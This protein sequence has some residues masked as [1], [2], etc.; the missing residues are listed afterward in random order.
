[1]PVPEEV[2]LR[3]TRPARYLDAEPNAV[4]KSHDE[5]LVRFVLAYPDV[6]EV[7]MSNLGLGLL[8]HALNA[9]DDAL[10]E[11][12]FCP[13]P[14]MEAELRR[15][16]IPLFALE[17]GRPVREFDLLG[18]SLQ[19]ELTYSNILN[20]LDLARVPLLAA[21]RGPGDP[22][23]VGGGPCAYNP[24]PLAPFFDLFFL[25]E[26]EEAVGEL[27]EVVA[28]GRRRGRWAVDGERGAGGGRLEL[29]AELARVPGVY[30]P[31]FYE[32]VYRDDGRVAEIRVLRDGVPERVVKRVVADLDR[33]PVPEAPVVPLV[34]AVHDRAAVEVMRGCARGC[35]FCQAGMIYRPVRERSPRRV[36]DAVRAILA[37]TG[38][39]EVSLASLST[40]DWGPVAAVLSH[41]VEEH[42]PKGIAVSLPSLRT[43]TFAVEL[44]SKIQEVRKTGLTFAPEAATARLRAVINKGVT[45]AD[46]VNAARAAFEAGWD[47]LKLYYMLGLPT[48][49]DEDLEAIA[50]EAAEVQRIYQERSGP[51]AARRPLLLTVSLATFIP[52]AHTPFQWAPQVTVE[53]AERRVAVVREAL[54][55]SRPGSA[56]RSKRRAGVKLDWHSPAMSRLEAVLARG[57]RR[58]HRAVLK[59]WRKGA[60]FDGWTEHFRPELWDSAFREEG[61]DPSFYANRA[62]PED[63]V[64]PWE[65]L[66]SGVEREFL[67]GEWHR[68]LAGVPTPD[69]RWTACA[70]CGV[71]ETT[72][73][74]NR[75]TGRGAGA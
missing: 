36:E 35:R 6:Y 3:V 54:G 66:S 7:G 53:E 46:L 1:M 44:A 67:L 64:F 42:G 4:H 23:V 13:W 14:D 55:G 28:S 47:R 16:G 60:R 61:L 19:Y 30:V 65:H 45:R 56:G 72:G 24:E 31:A 73:A 29:L 52:K 20:L 75:L 58:V 15:L 62:R 41:L 9:R 63:E 27:V 38:Y 71:C 5:G 39:G 8:Y 2:L 57:D 26:A 12:V 21:E 22:L 50:E 51:G 48:E 25:G 32:P 11:R 43:D 40:C 49:T 17:S 74:R 70:R 68:A 69:C 34:E 33:V 18:V 10:A 37:N 59:A